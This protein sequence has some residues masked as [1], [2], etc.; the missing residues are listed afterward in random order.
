MQTS[1]IHVGVSIV[2]WIHIQFF[3]IQYDPWYQNILHIVQGKYQ[4]QW[5]L[6]GIYHF[7]RGGRAVC[8]W[9]GDQTFFWV[10]GTS[11]FFNDSNRGPEFFRDPRG[12]TKILFQRGGTIC[13]LF[14]CTILYSQSVKIFNAPYLVCVI[15]V[16]LL[17]MYFG[18]FGQEYWQG[19][20]DTG[21]RQPSDVFI[22]VCSLCLISNKDI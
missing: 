6:I 17:P 5:L 22:C 12:A 10:R 4:N 21:G 13:F 18:I 14:F 19:G 15:V 20:H 11:F 9:R 16:P 8:L 7:L 2:S 1:N 3:S